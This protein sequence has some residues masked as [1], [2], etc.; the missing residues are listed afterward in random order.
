[1]L[2][3]NI[4]FERCVLTEASSDAA[5]VE[6]GSCVSDQD[7]GTIRL[8][9]VDFVENQ[10]TNA[11]GLNIDARSCSSVEM[12]DVTFEE[13]NCSGICGALLSVGSN[14]LRDVA[15]LNNR[16]TDES[17]D[18]SAMISCPPNSKITAENITS[19]GNAGAAFYVNGA[20]IVIKDS[21]F[22]E[23]RVG[24]NSTLASGVHLQDAKAKVDGC[25][26][27]DNSGELGTSSVIAID[28]KSV[29]I[30]D[31]SFARNNASDLRGAAIR[32][33]W[34]KSLKI[35]KSTF[36]NNIG[37]DGGAVHLEDTT[38]EF[39]DCTLKRNIAALS[40]GAMHVKNSVITI[41]G[42][43]FLHNNAAGDG[44]GVFAKLSNATFA[45]VTCRRNKADQGSQLF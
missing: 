28:C 22:E 24:A 38:A 14:V 13:N 10:L 9:H 34:T 20:S 44:G 29:E 35:R 36:A 26:F 21:V 45:N 6:V 32:S 16:E 7:S 37:P 12:V 41:S 25:R 5:I 15:M 42:C 39:E 3:A 40:G 31:C 33:S 18:T 17:A 4:A 27:R 1:V 30:T 2:F 23:N 19:R 8:H 11:Y 43:A